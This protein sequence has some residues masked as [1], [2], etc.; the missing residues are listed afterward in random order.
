M[1]CSRWDVTR[2]EYRGKITSLDL[3]A[4]FDRVD[5][6]SCCC[7]LNTQLCIYVYVKIYDIPK[8]GISQTSAIWK[9]E[10]QTSCS[11]SVFVGQ[12]TEG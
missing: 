11:S 6:M 8:P 2:V 3:L 7:F 4:R 5:H 1:Q 9:T 12:I 10:D